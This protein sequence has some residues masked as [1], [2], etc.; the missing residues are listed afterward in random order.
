MTPLKM[1]LNSANSRLL[2][3][4][5]PADRFLILMAHSAPLQNPTANAARAPSV[6]FYLVTAFLTSAALLVLELV[7]AR[8]IAPY[9]GVSLYTWTTIIGVILAGLSIGNGLGG[10]WADKGYGE[11]FAGLIILASGVFSWLSLYLIYPVAQVVQPS[12]LNV[13]T[14]SFIY[15]ASLFLMPSIAL[16]VI[17]PLLT[18]I[19]AR[20][21]K[22][23]GKIIGSM[24]AVAALGG[25]AGVFLTG[26]YLIQQFGSRQVIFSVAVM[27]MV[28]SIP[29]MVKSSANAINTLLF[30]AILVGAFTG[31]T[32]NTL[33]A[34]VCAE[35]SAYY[36]INVVDRSDDVAAGSARGLVLDHLLHGINH[37]TQPAYL[38]AAFAQAID[39]IVFTQFKKDYHSG[40]EY[41]FAGGGSYTL[42]R[43]IKATDYSAR[44]SVAEIDKSVTEISARQLF[45]DTRDFHILHTDARVALASRQQNFDVIITDVF[46]DIS[47]PHHL[48]TR[49]FTRLVD[50]RLNAKGIYLMNVVDHFPDPR[51]VKSIVK[52]LRTTF[53]HVDVWMD[54]APANSSRYTY[55]ISANHVNKMPAEII[56]RRGLARIWLNI[57]EVMAGIGLPMQALPIL[58]DNYAPVEKLISQ[59][60]IH[61][62]K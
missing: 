32:R 37:Q 44:I 22:N 9:V 60:L 23:A 42:P 51:L 58:T 56:A 19:A 25:I 34:K 48:L 2:P 29:Y 61:S 55:V 1:I 53:K 14:S 24:H 27:L 40:L 15:V 36:C 10:Y 54:H 6:A 18:T 47:I 43:A 8:I 5:H 12:S 45:V 49:E 57:S 13:L 41:F 33:F 39:E 11:K 52:T 16:G 30:M 38:I 20:Q 35:E 50:S 7:S 28:L 46:H 4:Q 21:S 17:T 62:Q 3:A 59:L 31:L 26:Y